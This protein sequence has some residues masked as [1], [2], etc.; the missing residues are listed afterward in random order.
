[1]G[2][3]RDADLPV[4]TPTWIKQFE[5]ISGPGIVVYAI[6]MSAAVIYWVVSA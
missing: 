1:M 2:I 4:T 3:R 6:T 5:N